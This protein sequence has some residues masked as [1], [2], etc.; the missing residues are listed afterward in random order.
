MENK[1]R[2]IQNNEKIIV[3]KYVIQRNTDS[4]KQ[5]TTSIIKPMN[6]EHS[7]TVEDRTTAGER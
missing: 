6:I 5:Y 3:I 7:Y 2:K 4:G 1:K